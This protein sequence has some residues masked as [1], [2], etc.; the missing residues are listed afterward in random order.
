MKIQNEM[1]IIINEVFQNG[2]FLKNNLKNQVNVR[3]PIKM[4]IIIIPPMNVP[5]IFIPV[6]IWNI[7]KIK[8]IKRVRDKNIE[9]IICL[10]LPII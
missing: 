9:K 2:I 4:P 7:L 10:L 8:I 1:V 3:Q 6:E 5:E